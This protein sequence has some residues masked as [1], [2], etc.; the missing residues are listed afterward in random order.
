MTPPNAE[1]QIWDDKHHTFS[2]NLD[3]TFR[4]YSEVQSGQEKG[5]GAF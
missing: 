4:Y 3:L 1:S 2:N 5:T